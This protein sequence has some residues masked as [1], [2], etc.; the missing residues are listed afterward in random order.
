M[1]KKHENNPLHFFRMKG[2]TCTSKTT[3]FGFKTV[4]ECHIVEGSDY[5]CDLNWGSV[6][7]EHYSNET[8]ATRKVI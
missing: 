1:K 7:K 8:L 5:W 6:A 2:L 3:K 4:L